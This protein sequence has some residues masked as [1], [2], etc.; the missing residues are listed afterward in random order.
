MI[1]LIIIVVGLTFGIGLELMYPNKHNNY[2][3]ND[4]WNK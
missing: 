1:V 2:D 4:T 3:N